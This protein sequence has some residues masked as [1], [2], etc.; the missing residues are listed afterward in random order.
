MQFLFVYMMPYPVINLSVWYLIIHRDPV[1]LEA[2]SLSY[3]THPKIKIIN[4]YFQ[5]NVSSIS[6]RPK[7]ER[8]ILSHK[9]ILTFLTYGHLEL[10][11]L[12]LKNLVTFSI[13]AVYIVFK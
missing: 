10:N 1:I 4:V 2:L 3:S 11:F 12:L 7:G 6:S 5:G 13:C 8:K 9:Q